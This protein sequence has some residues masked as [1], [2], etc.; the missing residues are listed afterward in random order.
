MGIM[1]VPVSFPG[2]E[3]Q[4]IADAIHEVVRAYPNGLHGAVICFPRRSYVSY[5]HRQESSHV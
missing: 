4:V 5:P 3:F 1:V 2:N